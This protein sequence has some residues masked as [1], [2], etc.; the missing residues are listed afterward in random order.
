MAKWANKRGFKPSHTQHLTKD[1][2]STPASSP[3]P[4]THAFKQL[5]TMSSHSVYPLSNGFLGGSTGSQGAPNRAVIQR[6][7]LNKIRRVLDDCMSEGCPC[8]ATELYALLNH[9]ETRRHNHRK[10]NAGYPNVRHIH[11]IK[12]RY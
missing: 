1:S 4:H 6:G 12:I 2:S 5:F 11:H 8:G 9:L 7:H 3:T 10:S